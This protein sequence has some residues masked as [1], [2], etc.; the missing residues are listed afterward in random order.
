MSVFEGAITISREKKEL[1][2][3]VLKTPF[4]ELEE[5]YRRYFMRECSMEEE[6]KYDDMFTFDV[7]CRPTKEMLEEYL[8]MNCEEYW[9]AYPIDEEQYEYGSKAYCDL[10]KKIKKEFYAT[11]DLFDVKI[12]EEVAFYAQGICIIRVVLNK[13]KG[14][15]ELEPYMDFCVCDGKA[16]F[17][18][19]VTEL[20][21]KAIIVESDGYTYKIKLKCR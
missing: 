2:N 7:S 4:A 8:E 10:E 9:E 1:F 19:P 5:E 14:M 3:H 13:E 21:R 20:G 17:E 16:S 18:T 12:P 11:H 15:C 6:W